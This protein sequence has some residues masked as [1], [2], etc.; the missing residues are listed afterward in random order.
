MESYKE[1]LI[2][3]LAKTVKYITNYGR[4]LLKL[5][6]VFSQ[7]PMPQFISMLPSILDPSRLPRNLLPLKQIT[8]NLII[9]QIN[10]LSNSSSA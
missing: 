10:R 4:N 2:F 1:G 7:Y 9:L 6:K 5:A 8:K 3:L